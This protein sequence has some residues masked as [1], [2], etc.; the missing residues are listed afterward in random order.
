MDTR[1]LRYFVQIVESGSL[2]KAS[3][4]LFIAQPA[5]SAQMARLE[6]EVGKPLLVRSAR[7]VVPTQ[8]GLALYEH[9][10]FVLR[11]LDEAVHVARQE[12]S[13]IKGRVTLGMD[14]T[15][16]A[17]LSLP[18]LTHLRQAYPG[19]LLNVIA[20]H[21][22]LLEDMARGGQLDVAILTGETAA[23]ELACEPLLDEDLFVLIPEQSTLVPRDKSSLTLAETAGLPLVVGSPGYGLRRRL[24]LE[25]ERAQLKV[26]PVAEIDSMLL[27]MR[28]V[29]AGGGATVQ[30]MAAAQAL[31]SPSHWRCLP[32]SDAP[33]TRR[34]YLYS[35]PLQKMSATVAIV[36]VELK[37]IVG[38]LIAS[39][40]WQGV[41]MVGVS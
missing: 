20:A 19:I 4:Q 32:I 24:N 8:N 25:F 11:Q 1:Q 38:G 17:V 27:V 35:L 21:P 9:A 39:G 14:A 34:N 22:T 33:M 37:Q 40:A 10:K 3:R 18:L 15:T 30:P 31:D 26:T 29:L 41:R 6:D 5:L 36:H 23:N 12:Y 13:D 28:F 2:S 16:A 7:G